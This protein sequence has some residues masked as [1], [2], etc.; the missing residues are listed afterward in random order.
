MAAQIE[1]NFDES[2]V[3][4]QYK[5]IAIFCTMVYQLDVPF[6]DTPH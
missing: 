4:L 1:V 2:K 5:I 6:K 3:L